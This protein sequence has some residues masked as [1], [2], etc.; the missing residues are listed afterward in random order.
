VPSCLLVVTGAP[1][2][3]RCSDLATALKEAGWS[4]QVVTTPSATAWVDDATISLAS[5]A[6][7]VSEHPVFPCPTH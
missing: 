7:A 4:V 3:I 5:G 1:L 2:A 6:P